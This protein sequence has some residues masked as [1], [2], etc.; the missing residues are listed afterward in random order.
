M[1]RKLITIYF[2]DLPNRYH[3]FGFDMMALYGPCHGIRWLVVGLSPRRLWFD[4]WSVRVRSVM[5]RVAPRQV[6]HRVLWI[7]SITVIPPV[8]RSF[9]VLFH[10]FIH[11]SL[12]VCN[13]S[14]WQR[15]KINTLKNTSI[16]ITFAKIIRIV[17]DWVWSLN[18]DEVFVVMKRR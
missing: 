10:S 11:P 16:C 2:C 6:F 18:I 13:L 5:D 4:P 14:I 9:S 15:R 8:L 7:L 1:Y 12:T 17:F 3:I